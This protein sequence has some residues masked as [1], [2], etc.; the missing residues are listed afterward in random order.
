MLLFLSLF[1]PFYLRFYTLETKV[2][3]IAA[4]TM[5]ALIVLLLNFFVLHHFVLAFIKRKKWNDTFELLWIGWNLVSIGACIFAYKIFNG[6][7]ELTWSNF[8]HATGALF[9]VGAM[10]L[11]VFFGVNYIHLLKKGSVPNSEFIPQTKADLPDRVV[12][13]AA[14]GHENLTFSVADLVYMSSTGNYLTICL[15]ADQRVQYFRIRNT[16]KNA[17]QLLEPYETCVRCH[18]AFIV[19][20]SYIKAIQGNALGYKIALRLTDEVIPVSRSYGKSFRKHTANLL[21]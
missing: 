18:R 15:R 2:A 20:L 4:Y 21:R 13:S 16:L 11:T 5:I 14:R 3:V 6:F 10:P 17:A 7:Y 8:F 1:Q 19:N 9:S 12:L